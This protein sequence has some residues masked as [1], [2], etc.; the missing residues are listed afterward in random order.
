MQRRI[1]SSSI[2]AGASGVNQGMRSNS[3]A[4]KAASKV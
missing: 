3:L 2:D 4:D 1:N